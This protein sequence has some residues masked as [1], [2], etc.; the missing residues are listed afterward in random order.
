MTVTSTAKDY[1]TLTFRL[2]ADFA[3]P[4]ERVWQLWEDPRKLERWWGPPTYPATFEQY[5]LAPGGSARYFMTSPEGARYYGWWR[6]VTVDP[7]H[8]LEVVDGFGDANGEPD[9]SEP[10]TTMRVE[11]SEHDG[12]TRME[13]SSVYATLDDMQTVIARGVVEGMSGAMGQMDALLDE[14]DAR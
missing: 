14:G 1:A 10:L 4:V 11:L 9:E 3:A 2:V 6:I 12:G 7:P 13:I 5:E 8:S